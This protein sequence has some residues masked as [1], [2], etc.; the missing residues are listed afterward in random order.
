MTP[1]EAEVAARDSEREEWLW[2]IEEGADVA[3]CFSIAG[4]GWMRSTCSQRV[5]WTVASSASGIL[6][7]MRCPE[8]ETLSEARVAETIEGAAVLADMR[9]R[10]VA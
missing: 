8:C 10:G 7:E 1:S 3:H 6:D 9:S 2:W 4:S 5:W